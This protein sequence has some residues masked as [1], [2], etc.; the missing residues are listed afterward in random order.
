VLCR[1]VENTALNICVPYN[2]GISSR[3]LNFDHR[4]LRM[5]FLVESVAV[6]PTSSVLSVG[7]IPPMLHNHISVLSITDPCN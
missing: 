7:I 3:K 1:A 5:Q 6:P 4:A 2:P